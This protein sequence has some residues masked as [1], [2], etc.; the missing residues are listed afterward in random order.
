MGL[1]ALDIIFRLEKS[2]GTMI[3]RGRVFE[4]PSRPT[5]GFP[6]KVAGMA[7]ADVP[8]PEKDRGRLYDLTAGQI[9]DRLCELMRE[10]GKAVPYS[11]W[12]RVKKCLTDALGVSPK[13]IRR[14]SRLVQDLSACF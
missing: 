7:A 6:V 5:F 12:H 8:M 3:P 11:S 1:D 9:H 2:F 14:D 4:E 13:L 10:Q